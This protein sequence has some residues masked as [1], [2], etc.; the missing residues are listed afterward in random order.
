MVREV[1]NASTCQKFVYQGERMRYQQDIYNL[2]CTSVTDASGAVS[3]RRS[4]DPWGRPRKTDGALGNGELLQTGPSH[5]DRGFTLH[6][7]L[8]GLDLIHM[9][10]RVYD[11]M[12]AEEKASSSKGRSRDNSC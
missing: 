5:T 4:F 11:P 3:E 2:P 9:N 10:G 6:E 12:L 1:G 8:E 7:H